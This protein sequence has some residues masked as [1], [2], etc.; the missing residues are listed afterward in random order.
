MA[1]AFLNSDTSV[2]QCIINVSSTALESELSLGHDGGEEFNGVITSYHQRYIQVS[3]QRRS[4]SPSP[5]SPAISGVACVKVSSSAVMT[6]EG[7]S[8]Q[9]IFS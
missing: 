4:T 5:H 2:C 8:S 3:F 1:L 7:V 6:C 9:N